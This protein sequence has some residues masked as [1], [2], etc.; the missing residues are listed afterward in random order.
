MRSR[1][2]QV[3]LLVL[4]VGLALA[5]GEA[6]LRAWA[7]V[8][9]VT[10]GHRFGDNA[11]RYGWGFGPRE[12]IVISDPDTGEVYVD[13]T[14]A[15]GWRDRDHAPGRASG[16]FRVLVL[17]DSVTYG[18]IVGLE[19]L[20]TRVLERQLQ[21]RGYAVEVVSIALG[22]WGTDH[23]LEALRL[24][25]L[26]YAPDLV[27]V[28]FTGND[29]AEIR[30]PMESALKP[31][32]YELAAD[33]SLVRRSNPYFAEK[34]REELEDLRWRRIRDRFEILKRWT[35]LR[36]R[37][38]G[39]ARPVAQPAPGQGRTIDYRVTDWGLTMLPREFGVDA[40]SEALK[41]LRDRRGQPV[42]EQELSQRI[43]STAAAPRADEALRLFENH[44]FA[45]N[46]KEPFDRFDAF[47]SRS[48]SGRLMWALLDEMLRLSRGA[49]A[50]F[51]LL[52]THERGQFEWDRFWFHVPD[53]LDRYLL[54]NE[55]IREWAQSRQVDF[56]LP[57]RPIV[58]AR[59]DPHPN[60][61]GNHVM[62]DTLA[63]FLED[64]YGPR[65]P[66]QK[67]DSTR[68]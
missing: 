57:E 15:A 53:R 6:A 34:N 1:L 22:R 24:E 27:V 47:N 2:Q 13:A 45:D 29:P 64:R 40:G 61:A 4:S 44:W 51:L 49:G 9:L 63:R 14:N 56:L 37:A 35:L 55:P 10:I 17:G 28:A 46:W 11:A 5:L 43:R 25:G 21:A 7:P 58:R 54:L 65:L 19:D 39:T 41:W 59:N 8:S 62:A 33:G 48:E 42:G 18:A 3:G 50:S 23:E 38:D 52:S 68:P 67:P 32:R 30:E 36:Q 66:R 12:T 60:R 31:F 20:Y 26:S 16:V